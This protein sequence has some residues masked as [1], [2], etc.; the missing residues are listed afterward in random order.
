MSDRW[1]IFWSMRSDPI[2]TVPANL[3]GYEG[4]IVNILT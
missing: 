1:H 4:F 3:T 2:V